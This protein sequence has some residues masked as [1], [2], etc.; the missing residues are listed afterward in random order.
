MAYSTSLDQ[1]P[2]LAG[3]NYRKSL[4]AESAFPGSLLDTLSAYLY[5]RDTL[6]FKPE[7][8]VLMGDSA[9]GGCSVGLAR[10]LGDLEKHR[11]RKGEESVGQVGGM[12]L[13]SV[14]EALSQGV[15]RLLIRGRSGSL[16]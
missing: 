7:N 5:L 3:A 8:I 9:G 11:Q 14:S 6:G 13:F 12:I 15:P 10:Y 1:S 2:Y 16:G 4:S